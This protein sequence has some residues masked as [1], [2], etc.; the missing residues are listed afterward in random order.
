MGGDWQRDL[1]HAPHGVAVALLLEQKKPAGH[2]TCATDPTG[3]KYPPDDV[4]ATFVDVVA[5]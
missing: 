5:Q 3:Q 4:H 2:R 1:V